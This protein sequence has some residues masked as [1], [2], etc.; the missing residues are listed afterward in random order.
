MSP[1][2]EIYSVTVATISRNALSIP[3]QVAIEQSEETVETPAL[4]DSGAGGKFIDQNFAKQFT[5]HKLDKPLKA[6]NV[7][8]TENKRGKIRHY[9]D[10]KFTMGKRTFTEQLLVTG[11]GK[12]KIILGFPWL[13]EQNPI[14]DWQNGQ[15]EW[16]NRPPRP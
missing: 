9:V 2:L 11:L 8:G 12:Q 16:R 10:L 1:S 5:I 13:N 15:I 6:Y 4:I 14:I 7:D 3:I